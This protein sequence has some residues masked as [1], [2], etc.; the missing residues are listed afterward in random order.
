[1]GALVK[2]SLSCC[3]CSNRRNNEVYIVPSSSFRVILLAE[4][5][6]KQIRCESVYTLEHFNC[7]AFIFD[8]FYGWKRNSTMPSIYDL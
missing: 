7:T 6:F 4:V 1:M 5:I 3:F 2:E 8:G